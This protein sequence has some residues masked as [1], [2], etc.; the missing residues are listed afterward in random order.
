MRT[1]EE[2]IVFITNLKNAAKELESAGGTL[3]DT[4]SRSFSR[5][6][7]YAILSQRPDATNCAGFHAWREAG[8]TIKRGA[9]G[10]AILIPMG[11]RVNEEG[12]DKPIFSW[13]YVYDVSDTET[14]REDSPKLAK[15]LVNA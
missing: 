7:C 12:E 13:R 15:D 8:R 6:N 1:R 14:L 3:P 11:T 4:L 2:K 5:F 10:I 9:K